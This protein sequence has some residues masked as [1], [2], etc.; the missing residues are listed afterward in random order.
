MESFLFLMSILERM[1]KV[2]S[3]N[4]ARRVAPRG[5]TLI[6]MIVVLVIITIIMAIILVNQATFSHSLLLTDTAYTV[7][8]SI[9]ETQS[10][11]LSSEKFSSIQNA[12]YGI[13]FL[14]STPSSY[15]QFADILPGSPT[16]STT[17]NAWCPAG[18]PGTPNAKP[19]NC[20]Y[21]GASE[22]AHTYVF[23]QAYTQGFCAYLNGV[24][25]GCSNS[26]GNLLK[27]LDIVFLRPNTSTIMTA[28]LSSGSEVQ[29]DTACIQVIAPGNAAVRYVKVT[30]LG[31]VSVAEACP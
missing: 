7:A 15:I 1:Q 20:V 16:N 5:F 28:T 29:A 22:L 23:N 14:A 31:E 11:G 30:Q 26:G 24:S 9:R 21:D 25:A 27:A 4:R 3:G 18:T 8:L 19:G 6:E 13:D 2:Y 17:N 12:G 10:L